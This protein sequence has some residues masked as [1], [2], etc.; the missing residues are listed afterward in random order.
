MAIPVCSIAGQLVLVDWC[1][2][3]SEVRVSFS[4]FS[5]V[6]P[7][8]RALNGDCLRE[9]LLG[10]G[11]TE[12]AVFAHKEPVVQNPVHPVTFPEVRI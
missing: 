7:R 5:V 3:E 11:Y 6:Q 8:R 12:N 2:S 9:K 4:V 10:V 1:N